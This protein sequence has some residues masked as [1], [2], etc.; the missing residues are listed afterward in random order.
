MNQTLFRSAGCIIRAGDHAA[1]KG[2]VHETNL[3]RCLLYLRFSCISYMS[4]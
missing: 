3:G 2:L 1:E 4:N